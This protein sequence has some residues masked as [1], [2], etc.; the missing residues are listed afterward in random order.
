M[1][2]APKDQLFQ[3]GD[4][5]RLSPEGEDEYSDQAKGTAGIVTEACRGW[6]MDYQV[7]WDCGHTNSYN[8]E[9]LLALTA[10][11]HP[12]RTVR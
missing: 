11:N 1:H 2:T 9:H 6:G 12:T 3:K 10:G 7:R 5:V 8:Q 4:R